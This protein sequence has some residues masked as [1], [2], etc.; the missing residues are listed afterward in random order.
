MTFSKS[1]RENGYKCIS[2][3]KEEQKYSAEKLH[4]FLAVPLTHTR[5]H[6]QSFGVRGR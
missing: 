3:L 5:I 1:S 2:F 4:A 6:L